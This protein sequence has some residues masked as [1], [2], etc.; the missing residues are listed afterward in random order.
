MS[1]PITWTWLIRQN[2]EKRSQR[3]ISDR[4]W[5]A[6]LIDA[7]RV[8]RAVEP[9]KVFICRGAS[10]KMNRASPVTRVQRGNQASTEE[11]KAGSFRSGNKS[12][13]RCR[14]IGL[15]FEPYQRLFE[16]TSTLTPSRYC[17]RLWCYTYSESHGQSNL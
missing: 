2:S 16:S 14:L 6:Q 10:M 3:P 12:L 11:G 13:I 1:S 15:I 5:V 17:E 7:V 9:S 8:Y 4:C